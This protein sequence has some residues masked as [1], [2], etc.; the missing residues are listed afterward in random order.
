[1]GAYP[2]MGGYGQPGYGAGAG[3]QP[4]GYGGAP[5]GAGYGGAPY[6]GV[7]Q[8]G[9]VPG[10][11][12]QAAVAGGYGGAPYGGAPQG[13]YSAGQGGSYSGAQSGGY[14]A[15]PSGAG[16][17]SGASVAACGTLRAYP[18]FSA[19][20]DAQALRTAMKGWG[21]DEKAIIDVLCARS[22]DQ[23]QEIVRTYKQMFGRDLV[24]DI[25]SELRGRFEAVM[26]GL[27]YPME[28]FLA[29]E[30]RAAMKGLG[31]DE[32]CLVEILCTRS[33]KDI[34]DIK[35]C[36]AQVFGRDLEND[37]K[38]ETS[39]DFRRILI[40]MCNAHRQEGSAPNPTQA[41]ND[42]HLL[43]Q[44]GVMKWGTE[45]SVFNQI[46]ANQSYEHLRLVFQEYQN[47][48]GR[49]ILQAIQ[50]EMSGDLRTAYLAIAKCVINIP[51]YFA[52]KLYRAMKGAGTSDKALVRIIVTRC[53]VDLVQI[54]EEYV[55][56]FKIPLHD[57]IRTD[58]SGDYRQALLLLVQGN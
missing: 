47:L 2:P 10:G 37:I 31:T 18:N 55:R 58:T 7:Q 27:L 29:R 52:E 16:S 13:G 6:G 51:F 39:G 46:L 56:N 41:R 36:Y 48:T 25:R 35:E 33:N 23:R 42:A 14:A 50:S 12:G 11:F 15:A 30:L 45:E 3:Q 34:R 21:T 43:Q 49:S 17:S 22:G 44:A 26:L 9:S 5:T 54:K 1:M 32:D 28:E 20:A 19:Q 4:G 53:E 8:G 38:S 24:A 57:A 40:S